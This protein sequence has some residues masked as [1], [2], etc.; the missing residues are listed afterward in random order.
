M[1][2][3]V[4]EKSDFDQILNEIEDFWGSRRTACLH[5]PVF[6]YE[7]GNTAYVI[8]END[9]VVAY[10][11]GFLSQTSP[12]AYIHLIAVRKSH[13]RLGLGQSLFE[14]FA[15]YARQHGCREIKA[16]TSPDNAASVAFHESLGMEA[17][18]VVKDYSGPGIDRIVFKKAL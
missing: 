5:H 10:L 1:C 3:T 7:F 2:I 4:C 11:F 8:K 14:H 16:I 9:R 15:D 6:L 17:S 18:A 13:R 12:T